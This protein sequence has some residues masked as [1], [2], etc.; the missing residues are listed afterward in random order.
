MAPE[1]GKSALEQLPS[2][3]FRKIL[4]NLPGR[5]MANLAA[6]SSTM[7]S[8][9]ANNI[10]PITINRIF[11]PEVIKNPVR[12]GYTS[13]PRLHFEQDYHTL[14]AQKALLGQTQGVHAGRLQAMLME[15]GIPPASISVNKYMAPPGYIHAKA[16]S[17]DNQF[18]YRTLDFEEIRSRSRTERLRWNWFHPD[19]LP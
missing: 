12:V 18:L 9:V 13:N 5:D 3:A 15:Q 11:N 8:K 2:V 4:E 16:F 17:H 6:T 1:A 10:P 14:R 7:A 19:A